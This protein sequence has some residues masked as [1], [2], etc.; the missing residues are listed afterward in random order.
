[1]A[2]CRPSGGWGREGS[3]VH[4]LTLLSPLP[5]GVFIQH[6]DGEAVEASGQAQ[7]VFLPPKRVQAL[8][9]C[10]RPAAMGEVAAPPRENTHPCGSPPWGVTVS[11]LPGHHFIVHLDHA[12]GI[13]GAGPGQ[14]MGV[15]GVSPLVWGSHLSSGAA[16]GGGG[17]CV[18]GAG[19]GHRFKRR[20]KT[21]VPG[22][23]MSRLVSAQPH[24]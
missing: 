8:P 20:S 1:M 10:G 6:V 18:Q 19:S 9:H 24:S 11:P 7:G 15:R 3:P 21:A 17:G 22:G 13:A 16:V 2:T 14:G 12:V 4:T 5:D 23:E